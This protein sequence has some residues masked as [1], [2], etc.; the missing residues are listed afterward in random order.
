MPEGERR[1]QSVLK[2]PISPKRSFSWGCAG[3]WRIGCLVNS[4]FMGRGAPAE[5]ES[6]AAN[7]RKQESSVSQPIDFLA[8]DFRIW[9]RRDNFATEPG[10]APC[11]MFVDS[12]VFNEH[13]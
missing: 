13:S 3:M 6:S 2:V 7:Y 9:P 10:G 5:H 12:T 1:W 11:S 4:I 8:A